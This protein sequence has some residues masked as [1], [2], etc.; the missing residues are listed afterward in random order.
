L[1]R[2]TT[3]ARAARYARNQLLSR[4]VNAEIARL[5]YSSA[6]GEYVCECG[7][8]TCVEAIHLTTE[9]FE[10]IRDEPALFVVLPGHVDPKTERVV[11][12]TR[13]YL[14]VERRSTEA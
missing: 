7:L 10:A 8:K 3:Q 11:R 13:R 6:F 5:R 9:E 1:T 12:E 2:P 14:V 4:R